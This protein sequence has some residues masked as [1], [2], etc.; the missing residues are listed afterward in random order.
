M[1]ISVSLLQQLLSQ[2]HLLEPLGISV[3]SSLSCLP[4]TVLVQT[5]VMP[6]LL[7]LVAHLP[8]LPL[9][10]LMFWHCVVTGGIHIFENEE[11]PGKES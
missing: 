5:P 4:T 1:L 2:L 8:T 3:A 9:H 10:M 6:P 11:G 7:A